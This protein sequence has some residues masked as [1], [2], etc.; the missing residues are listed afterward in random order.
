MGT[1]IAMKKAQEPDPQFIVGCTEATRG[2]RF[3]WA[4]HV[5]GPLAVEARVTSSDEAALVRVLSQLPP[6]A[7]V[8]VWKQLDKDFA[9]DDNL[10]QVSDWLASIRAEQRSKRS[11]R[12]TIQ[13]AGR[14]EQGDVCE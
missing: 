13:A 2:G 12:S 6:D 11:R 1:V 14:Q 4:K 8:K 9:A 10:I 5:G 7:W 3:A